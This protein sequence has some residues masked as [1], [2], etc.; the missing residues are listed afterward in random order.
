M[1]SIHNISSCSEYNF[2]LKNIGVT[3]FFYNVTGTWIL[4]KNNIP[5][6]TGACKI[7]AFS[8]TKCAKVLTVLFTSES[9]RDSLAYDLEF[10]NILF[11]LKV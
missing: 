8:S 7:A 3:I 1:D 5:V 2:T 11:F 4:K 6:K 9:V 10:C